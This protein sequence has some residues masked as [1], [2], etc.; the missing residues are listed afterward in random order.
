MAFSATHLER[1]WVAAGGNP[2]KARLAAA[3]ALAESS[4][5]VNASSH[6]PV[7]GG[8]NKGLWQIDA[9]S[10]PDSTYNPLGNAKAAVRISKKGKDF[11]A[12][13]TYATGAYKK[14]LPSAAHPASL[15]GSMLTPRVRTTPGVSRAPERA[16]AALGFLF[17]QSHQD[18]GPLSAAGISTLPYYGQNGLLSLVQT[19]GSLQDTPP[20]TNVSFKR[21]RFGGAGGGGGYTNPF[22]RAS[23]KRG[24]T[25]QGVD[26]SGR[27]PL[28]ALG[29][30]VVTKAM[31]GGSGWPEGGY[32]E[33]K[34]LSG[35]H[36]GRHV[37]YA[38]G[39]RPHVRVGQRVR[40]GQKVAAITGKSIE[41]GW[42]AGGPGTQTYAR[43]HGGYS[44]GQVTRPGRRF[45]RL[46]TRIGA[47]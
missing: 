38:E 16:Q 12:W 46:L 37:Y 22:G 44:E 45:G 26:Y 1:L 29:D 24:R 18:P 23:V 27:G 6:N 2:N 4:G 14:H 42:A 40:A 43:T 33:Y 8:T 47:P 15:R 36:A 20:K 34:L 13:E 35:P 17:A 5:K 11:S 3:I 30:A 39:L 31:S 32:V 25:D 28:L 9:G 7:S 10:H 19:L 21:Q 41:V